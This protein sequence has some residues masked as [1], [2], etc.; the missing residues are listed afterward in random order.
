M[1]SDV[2]R[3][4]SRHDARRASQSGFDEA[5]SASP[6]I[7][8][9]TSPSRESSP[10]LAPDSTTRMSYDFGE[11]ANEFRNSTSSSSELAGALGSTTTN[12]NNNSNNEST[13]LFST[14]P[15]SYPGP[16]HPDYLMQLC[17]LN[18]DP[19]PF[20]SV[21]TTTETDPTMSPRSTKRRRMSTD[22]ATEPPSSAVSYSSYNSSS[23]SSSS[24]AD[25]YTSAASTPSHHSRKS[26]L[27]FPFNPFTSNGG[28]NQGPAL[29]GSGNTFW[30]PP[31]MPQNQ[32]DAEP[33]WHPPLVPPTAHTSNVGFNISSKDASPANNSASVSTNARGRSISKS[34]PSNTVDTAMDFFQHGMIQDDDLFSAYLH[35]HD[36]KTCLSVENG[37]ST[38]MYVDSYF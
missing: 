24:S 27:D 11:D 37:S 15:P 17:G 29:R 19:L 32:A 36:E 6:E 1:K 34:P 35:A 10:T 25:G 4:R 18:S 30:H 33:F 16:Y 9:R 38:A 28:I 13:S 31:M 21:E 7:S 3:K 23:I 5:T 20:S 14:F 22:S 2:I 12:H 26:S 8:C